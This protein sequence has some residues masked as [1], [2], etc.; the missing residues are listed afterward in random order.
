M[1]GQRLV[2]LALS[3]TTHRGE[4]VVVEI[5]TSDVA[6]LRAMADAIIVRA[7]RQQSAG[8]EHQEPALSAA[9]EVVAETVVLAGEQDDVPLLS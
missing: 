5:D 2:D 3:S 4:N 6:A 8:V 9:T 7:V 1:E